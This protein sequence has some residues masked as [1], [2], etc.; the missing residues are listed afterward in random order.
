M[1]YLQQFNALVL[2]VAG[3]IVILAMGAI[4]VIV[5]YEVFCRYVLGNM[6]MWGT[7][8]LQY[9]LVWAT[10]LGGAVGLK[11]GYQIGI[12]S[13]SDNLSAKASAFVQ[14]ISYLMVLIFL[15]FVT[16]YGFDQALMNQSQVSSTMNIPMSI[17]YLALPIGFL[18]MVLVT[19]EQLIEHLTCKS[20]RD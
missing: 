14:T 4:A 12:T 19:I 9:S 11:R 6:S 18:I 1:L 8:F 16:Y 5:P 2:K 15:C 20:R 7:E 13:L 3:W 17:P 10:M